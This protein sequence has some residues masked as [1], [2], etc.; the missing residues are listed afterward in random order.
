MTYWFLATAVFFAATSA[1]LW[2][3]SSEYLHLWRTTRTTLAYI[4]LDEEE[5]NLIDEH[6]Y[7]QCLVVM[8]EL[9]LMMP[10]ISKIP[11]ELKK[12]ISPRFVRA[13]NALSLTHRDIHDDVTNKKAEYLKSEMPIEGV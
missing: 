2:K 9:S 13:Y 8:T 6:K 7:Q 11:P 3:K 4:T 1:Y 12:H 10:Y 5:R